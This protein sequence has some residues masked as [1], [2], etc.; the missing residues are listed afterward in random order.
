MIENMNI[1]AGMLE[2][3]GLAA[4]VVL[5]YRI[6]LRWHL[7][8][9]WR[10]P[11][12]GVLFGL[13]AVVTMIDPFEVS[14]GVMIDVRNVMIA[15]AAVFGGVWSAVIAGSIAVLV[16]IAI[17]GAGLLP[18]TVSI[19]LGTVI[20]LTFVHF[21]GNRR[22]LPTLALLGLV[23]SFSLLSAL[24]LPVDVL[25][26]MAVKS[27]PALIVR[28][29]VGTMLVGSLL[30]MEERREKEYMTFKQ[31]AERDALTGLSNRR[32]LELV[33]RRTPGHESSGLF[34]VI[35]FDLDHFKSVNDTYGHSFGD[36]VLARFAEIISMR[37]RGSDL[38]VRYGGE[39]FCVIL[40]DARL[41]NAERIAEDIRQQLARENFSRNVT[42]TASAGVAQSS[43]EASSVYTVIKNADMALYM[44]K[45]KGRNEVVTY[46]KP[47]YLPG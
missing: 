34:C 21:R 15:L 5:T 30:A 25:V 6:I 27:L 23:I 3:V 24:L 36:V 46:S 26:T 44:A 45:H 12:I 40:N 7:P 17:G 38:V 41:D 28:N 9:L 16:R 10:G 32:A 37:I 47:V 18:G 20:A 31:L 42:V 1:L 33:E 29:I 4:L 8:A 22:D 11:A 14:P 35:M 13:A 43:Q 2:K 39:E 19:I